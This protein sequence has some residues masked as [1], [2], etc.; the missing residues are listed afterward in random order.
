[1]EKLKKGYIAVNREEPG[2]KTGNPTAEPDGEPDE[3]FEKYGKRPPA[4]LKKLL[5]F[6]S[7]FGNHFSDEF[8]LELM[9]KVEFGYTGEGFSDSFIGLGK[10]NGSGSLY[11]IWIAGKDLEKCPIVVFGD[12]GGIPVV[13][14]NMR[15]FIR[16]LT[17]DTE[18]R[19]DRPFN[20]K[21]DKAEFYKSEDDDFESPNRPEFL[22]WAKENFGVD[23]IETN[24]EA[25]K[26]VSGASEKL[27]KK[28]NAFLKKYKLGFEVD[29]NL[30]LLDSIYYHE[31]DV[32]TVKMLLK[33]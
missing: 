33:N 5:G 20:N 13:A 7:E 30:E 11:A 31:D 17:Y 14:E 2:L 16:L 26:I 6:K 25:R 9:D 3:F 10:A 21:P 23:P 22:K 1:L 18:V 24:D 15:Q 4:A 12:E 19:I 8:E 28:Y 29:K 32:D 27:S